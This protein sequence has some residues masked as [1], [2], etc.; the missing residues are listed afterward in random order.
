MRSVPPATTAATP[1]SRNAY[2]EFDRRRR[3]T[4]W[5]GSKPRQATRRRS[6][7]PSFACH[8]QAL[9]PF[10]GVGLFAADVAAVLHPANHGGA[11][12]C[13]GGGV[14]VLWWRAGGVTVRS[15]EGSHH[16]G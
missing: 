13:A 6:T 9:R 8:G 1:R 12:G 5:C 2:A 14:R 10:G 4:R 16:R 3:P 11:D 15:D 7:S